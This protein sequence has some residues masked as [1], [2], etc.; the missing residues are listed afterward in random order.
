MS[1]QTWKQPDIPGKNSC[2]KNFA[3]K[4]LKDRNI[5]NYA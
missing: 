4:T 3:E 5:Q 1:K 2:S